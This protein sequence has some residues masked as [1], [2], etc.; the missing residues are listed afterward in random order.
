MEPME[1]CLRH[2]KMDKSPVHGVVLVGGS[3][4]IPK[5]QQFLKDFFNGMVVLCRLLKEEN[6]KMKMTSYK[7]ERWCCAD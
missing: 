5:F 4:K 6:P 3:I 2:A 7:M 1:K